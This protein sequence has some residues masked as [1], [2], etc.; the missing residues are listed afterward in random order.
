VLYSFL[1]I[2]FILPFTM[3][4]GYELKRSYSLTTHWPWLIGAFLTGLVG[5]VLAF[6]IGDVWGNFALH[7]SGGFASTL[8]FVYF[9]Q[10]LRIT[11]NWRL[12]TVLLFGFVCTLG[13]LNELAEFAVELLGLLT[14]SFDSQ[15]TWRDF[16]ANTSGAATAWLLVTALRNRQ[17]QN[18]LK[19]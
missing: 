14:M 2:A 7:A 9:M 5:S 17:L 3:W 13:V 4:L 10:T 12:T 1:Y 16:V 19:H 11:F 6:A 15:D 8:L 18:R